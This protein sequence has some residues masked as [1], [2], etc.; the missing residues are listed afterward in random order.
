M[1][2]LWS[3]LSSSGFLKAAVT[4]IWLTLAAQAVGVLGGAILL[5]FRISH[6]WWLRMVASIYLLIFRGT[7]ELLQLIAWY[8]V[9]PLAG[10]NLNLVQIA[11]V[12]LGAN[13]VARMVELLRSALLAVD[14]GQRE[15]AKAMGLSRAKSMVYV[16]AP[17]AARAAV[18]GLGNEV[19]IMFKTTA[20]VSVI[21]MTDLLRE[22]Q[23]VA[24]TVSNPL[25]PYV[26]ALI[27][28]L[29]LTT[30]W[31]AIQGQ[32]FRQTQ[33]TSRKPGF[34]VSW[35]SALGGQIQEG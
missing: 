11:I 14:E 18:A 23:L 19:N 30:V 8:A 9:L 1:S 26:A 29:G 22:S 7:P 35:W 32:I 13:E 4:T 20:L 24:Q 17:Q 34:L 2:G 25:I 3:S 33:L 28:Y 6:R 27:Y 21:G 16:I 12:G 10:V 31:G 15:A 5:P